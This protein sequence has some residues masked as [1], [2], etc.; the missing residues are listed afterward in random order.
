MV[1]L[2]VELLGDKYDDVILAN[3][4]DTEVEDRNDLQ[5]DIQDDLQ[6]GFQS[7]MKD[8]TK[9]NTK[10]DKQN[11]KNT[12]PKNLYTTYTKNTAHLEQ[13]IKDLQLEIDQLTTD[14]QYNNNTI[15]ELTILIKQQ[16]RNIRQAKNSIQNREKQNKNYKAKIMALQKRVKV[17]QE[18]LTET[19]RQQGFD[20]KL[21]EELNTTDILVTNN[22]YTPPGN[23]V[24]NIK[25]KFQKDIATN[26]VD[27]E[28][29]P[30]VERAKYS[31]DN[32]QKMRKKED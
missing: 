29:D 10:S 5:E 11:D 12:N 2:F 8:D 1:N 19:R 16:S 32:I 25:G 26:L 27:V 28:Y 13:K 4:E 6:D 22:T 31:Y 24:E 7:D 23:D 18:I 15:D 21:F 14:I 17:E 3:R 30:A 9:N 20:D